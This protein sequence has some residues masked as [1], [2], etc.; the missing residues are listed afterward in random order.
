M[1][2]EQFFQQFAL[3]DDCVFCEFYSVYYRGEFLIQV[4]HDE[5]LGTL[6]FQPLYVVYGV[7]SVF[8]E[9]VLEKDALC[10]QKR[11]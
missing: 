11:V 7:F 9:E 5:N 6:F 3:V 8:Y 10:F 1:A 2:C 4:G